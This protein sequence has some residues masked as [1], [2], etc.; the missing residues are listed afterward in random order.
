MSLKLIRQ[1]PFE[2]S[3]AP[4]FLAVSDLMLY[5]DG[6]YFMRAIAHSKARHQVLLAR[7]PAATESDLPSLRH[8]VLS[9]RIYNWYAR[10]NFLKLQLR[11]KLTSTS[12]LTPSSQR[13]TWRSQQIFQGTKANGSLR[14]Q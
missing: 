11:G 10:R 9:S 2:G 6:R 3:A 7:Q 8:A 1:Q 4:L 12:L 14:H 13:F 5:P